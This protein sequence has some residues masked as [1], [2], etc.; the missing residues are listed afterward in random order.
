MLRRL[1]L[2]GVLAGM[3]LACSESNRLVI[4]PAPGMAVV[5]MSATQSTY[6]VGDT[7]TVEVR[8]DNAANVGSVPFHLRY[9]ASV[10]QFAPPATEG[11]FMNL[12]GASTVFLV[13]DAGSEIIVGISR[14]SAPRGADGSGV[15]LQVD[16]DAIAP[17]DARL[18]FSGASVKD[19]LAAN[20]PATFNVE[21]VTIQP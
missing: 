21:A 11:P 3:A 18:G 8:I 4:P 6:R 9:D 12:D 10:L 1:F 20:L 7:V 14:L 5:S 17:G 13:T 15:L 2:V 16:F 19:P